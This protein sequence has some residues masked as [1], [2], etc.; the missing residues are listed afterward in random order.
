M[1]PQHAMGIAALIVGVILLAFVMPTRKKRQK[2]ISSA[3]DDKKR[4]DEHR[5][6]EAT[7]GL[8]VE[9]ADLGRQVTNQIDN[10]I[11]I[12]KELVAQS[13]ANIAKLESLN[14]NTAPLK[15]TVLQNTV[16]ETPEDETEAPSET[17]QKIYDLADE[18]LSARDIAE[19]T[20]E[21]HGEVELILGLRKKSAHKSL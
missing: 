14:Q 2:L 13:D 8:M 1:D 3:V 12:L 15:E 7:D 6:R 4:I 21:R 18:G 5:I 16:V 17:Q 10:K 19:K 9:M 11:S 20:G